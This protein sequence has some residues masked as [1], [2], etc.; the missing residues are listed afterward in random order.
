MSGQVPES[1]NNWDRYGL[2]ADMSGKTFLDV[3]CWEG[4]NCAE[5]RQRGATQVV[6]VDL[7]TSEPL[8]SNVEE[9]GFEFVQMDILSEKWLE[10]DTFDVVLCG[11]VLYHVENVISLLFR[12]RRVT[13]ER[14]YVETKI[15]DLNARK[16]IMLF[17]ASGTEGNPS[18]W[19]FPNELGLME[20]MKT[21]GFDQLEKT[22]ENVGGGGHRVCI[23]ARPVRQ[24]NFERALPR[25]PRRMPLAGGIRPGSMPEEDEAQPEAE[26]APEPSA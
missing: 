24:R 12:L 5:A 23:S 3:G 7:C 26:P 18:N 2:P 20:M 21:C 10:L 4:V 17:K 8:R 19:W 15:A 22:W 11:G 1:H 13:D 25:A 6:G 9:F 16:P 14:L